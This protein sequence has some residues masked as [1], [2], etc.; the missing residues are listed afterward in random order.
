MNLREELTELK[1]LEFIM[2]IG[3]LISPGDIIA[4]EP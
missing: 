1:L 4:P 3:L 2:I